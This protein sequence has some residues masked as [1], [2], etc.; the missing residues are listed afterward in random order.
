MYTQ[1]G[2][3]SYTIGVS[4]LNLGVLI[5][6]VG[7]ASIFGFI[8]MRDTLVKIMRL[9]ESVRNSVRGH[10]AKELIHEFATEEGEVAE[11][12]KSF[13]AIIGQLESNIDE[14]EATKEKLHDVLTKVGKALSSKEDFESLVHLVLET[15]VE[16]LDACDG[17]VFSLQEDQNHKL[18]ALVTHSQITR[19][20]AVALLTPHLAL[21]SPD[22]ELVTH[23]TPG[24]SVGQ[25]AFSTPLICAP[26][27]SRGVVWGALFIAGKKDSDVFSEDDINIVRNLSYQIAISFENVRLSADNEQA[28]F[29]TI[30]ALALAV[31]ARDPYS[32][33]HS[34]RVSSISVSIGEALQLAKADVETLR[35]AARLHDIGKIGVMDS[36][37]EKEGPLTND[38]RTMMQRHTVIGETIVLPLKTFHSLLDPIRHHHERLDGSGYPDGL[39]APELSRI[40]RVLMVADVYDAITSK[41]PYRVAMP[42]ADVEA[43]FLR[44]VEAG[45]MDPEIVT[46]FIRLVHEG[47]IGYPPVANAPGEYSAPIAAK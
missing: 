33:G 23:S 47:D 12:A 30:S 7:V 29:E 1:Y 44:E 37:L 10:A 46:E 31:E 16:A 15:S 21:I 34:E 28:Y 38:E 2:H 27:T 42:W 40:T 3:G 26:L 22:A 8:T 41:R 17:A 5:I 20:E 36:I 19:A 24:T 9:A 32:R 39:H 14:L 35:D 43:L 25:K 45:R 18:E 6:L 4:P 11:I 13:N